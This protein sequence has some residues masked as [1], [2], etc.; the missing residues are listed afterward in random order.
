M[1]LSPELLHLTQSLLGS[2][3][4]RIALTLSLSPARISGCC[5][6]RL[7]VSLAVVLNKAGSAAE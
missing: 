6:N 2:S 5:C 4:P 3:C 1:G 7:I